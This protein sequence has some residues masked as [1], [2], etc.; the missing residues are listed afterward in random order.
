[1]KTKL[2]DYE[3]DL[4][5]LASLTRQV[6]RSLQILSWGMRD[7]TVSEK[8]FYNAVFSNK[9]RFSLDYVTL[10]TFHNSMVSVT[11]GV[12]N[13]NVARYDAT[14]DNVRRAVNDVMT[15]LLAVQSDT[16]NPVVGL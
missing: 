3:D 4:E 5:Y 2:T 7:G 13:L 9:T 1:M 12:R 10:L 11:P 8:A 16:S 6:K 14:D 15:T